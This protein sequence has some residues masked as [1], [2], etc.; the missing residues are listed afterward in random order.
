QKKT[1]G[2]AVVISLS[3]APSEKQIAGLRTIFTQR[4]GDVPV[5]FLID[6][7]NRRKRIT[8]EYAI[9]PTDAVVQAIGE[10]VGKENVIVITP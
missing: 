6:A 2:P 7:G 4:T 9:S 8:T 5:Q 3:L 1:Q 10:I